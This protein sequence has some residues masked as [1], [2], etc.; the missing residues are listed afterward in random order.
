MKLRIALAQANPK[1]GDLA[2]NAALIRR[3]RDTAAEQSADVVVCPELS[4]TGSEILT[5][6]EGRPVAAFTVANAGRNYGYLS[7]GTLTIRHTD[8]TGRETLRRTLAPNDIQQTI[9]YG[10]VG[11][12]MSRRFTTAIE[13]ESADGELEVTYTPGRGRR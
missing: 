8:A 13:L 1:V 6:G 10:L 2:G 12:E 9:G 4:I 11:P 7:T 3:L 5:N